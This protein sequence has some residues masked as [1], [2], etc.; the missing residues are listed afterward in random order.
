MRKDDNRFAKVG[1]VKISLLLYPLARFTLKLL[2]K[3]YLT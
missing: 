3:M 1:N 2:E